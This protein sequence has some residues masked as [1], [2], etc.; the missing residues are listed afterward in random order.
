ML[1]IYHN[2]RCR[3]SREALELVAASGLPY[4]VI[5]YQKKPLNRA[6]LNNLVKK[7]GISAR[8]LIRSNESL[9]KEIYKDQNLNDSDCIALMLEH[10]RLME[11]PILV[12]GNRAVICRPPEMCRELFEAK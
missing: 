1:T 3:K 12:S 8:D 5:D 6:T 10:P 4:E 9:W 2:P 7:L 11:R